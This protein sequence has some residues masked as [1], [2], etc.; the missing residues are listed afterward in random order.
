MNISVKYLHD[1]YMAF[2]MIF[3]FSFFAPY[4]FGGCHGNQSNSV[5]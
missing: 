5:T 1:P 3:F 4:F 2:E